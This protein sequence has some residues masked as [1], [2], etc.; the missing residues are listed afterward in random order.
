MRVLDRKTAKDLE[1]KKY[2]KKVLT[3]AARVEGEFCAMTQEG[4]IS[5]KDGYVA[6]DESGY[7]YPIAYREF[8]KLYE[9]A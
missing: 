5:C 6:L 8:H 2:R 7:P 3:R 4:P 1:F 9:D